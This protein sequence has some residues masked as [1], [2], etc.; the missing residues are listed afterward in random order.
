MPLGAAAA[1]AAVAVAVVAAAPSTQGE[2]CFL[3][4]CCWAAC[5]CIDK[6]PH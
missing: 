1:A 2:R 4:A 5:H 6:K 3:Y